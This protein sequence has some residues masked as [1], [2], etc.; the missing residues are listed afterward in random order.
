MGLAIGAD[1]PF[2]FLEGAAIGRG[3][4][5]RLK[6]I[7]LPRL[8]Y[9]LVY[10]NFEVS[11]RWAY[12]NFV[13][14]KRRFHYKI[15]EFLRTPRKISSILRNDLETVVSRQYPQIEV[16]KK[17]LCSAGAL[18]ALMTGSGPTVFGLFPGEGSA[19]EA[20]RKVKKM[21]RGEGWIVLKAHS[22]SA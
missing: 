15:H 20:Y 18:A 17:N 7:E 14:T 12:Q 4:G 13:L 9:V 5:E 6:R 10:P 2:F 21:V 11:A 19:S 8:W 1:V 16:M 22:I 3:I